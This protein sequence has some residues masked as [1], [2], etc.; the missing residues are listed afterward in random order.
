[1][2]PAELEL[3]TGLGKPDDAKLMAKREEEIDKMLTIAYS[4]DREAEINRLLPA[5]LRGWRAGVGTLYENVE[6]REA[7]FQASPSHLTAMMYNRATSISPRYAVGS[8][9]LVKR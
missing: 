4:A 8:H 1:M 5:P 7:L 2:P 9:T 6:R 3:P